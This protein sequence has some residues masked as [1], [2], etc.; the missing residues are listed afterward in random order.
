MTSFTMVNLAKDEDICNR[1][2]QLAFLLGIRVSRTIHMQ[3]QDSSPHCDISVICSDLE[4][5]KTIPEKT[6]GDLCTR[7]KVILM[8]KRSG[9]YPYPWRVPQVYPGIC[10][11]PFCPLEFR[12]LICH[13]IPAEF[14][15]QRTMFLG[16]LMIDQY[17]REVRW[18]GIPLELK[19]YDYDI[20][21]ILAERI[22]QVVPENRSTS[23]TRS[24]VRSSLRHVDTHIKQI[25]KAVGQ[26]DMIQCVRSI[27]Y[28]IPVIA[29]KD[30]N[31]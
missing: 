19:G 13:C 9:Q 22:G 18:K 17:R 27:G 28:R 12:R 21:L 7:Q 11:L 3:K 29:L 16:N 6:L 1:I 2:Q 15:E 4:G 26:R 5:L 10:L 24:S 20:L 25:R 23:N 8:S 14:W 30:H 31:L